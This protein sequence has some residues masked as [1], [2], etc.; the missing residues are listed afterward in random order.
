MNICIHKTVDFF[1]AFFRWEG[2]IA[3]NEKVNRE[4]A[5]QDGAKG[6]RIA[7]TLTKRLSRRG[8][9]FQSSFNSFTEPGNEGALPV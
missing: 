2:L 5:K 9:E 1:P 8:L 7:P 4:G 3:V 6:S